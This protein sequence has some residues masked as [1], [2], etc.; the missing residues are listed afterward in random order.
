MRVTEQG[1]KVQA[2]VCRVLGLAPKGQQRLVGRDDG[3]VE[4]LAVQD[5]ALSGAHPVLHSSLMLKLQ[6]CTM[7]SL[8]ISCCPT[9]CKGTFTHTQPLQQPASIRLIQNCTCTCECTCGE[10]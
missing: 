1:A 5:L 9:F 7:T 3:R 8:H 2:V 10:G 6:H 4:L